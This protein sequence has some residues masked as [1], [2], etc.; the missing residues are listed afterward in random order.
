MKTRALTFIVLI[1]SIGFCSSRAGA[2]QAKPS[3][4]LLRY[5]V[6]VDFS[7]LTRYAGATDAGFGGRFTYNINRHIALEA[8]G[9]F[10]PGKCATC[11]G[12]LTGHITEGL[13]GIKAGQRFKK[14]GIFGKARPGLIN[15][16]KGYADIFPTGG[17]FSLTGGSGPFPFIFRERGHT[18]FAAD[19]GGVLEIYP[20][21]RFLLRFDAGATFDRV[22]RHT[23]HYV[24]IDP[25][26]FNPTPVTF[27]SS[28]YT[29]RYFQFSAGVGFRF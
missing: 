28:A 6:G 19:L 22:G 29:R 23:F 20:K 10:F 9:Y 12:E 18:D 25:V 21:K 15:F 17:S 7:S 3:E 5:E 26:T 27:T 13:F 11:N 1:A 8:A 24:D 4:E 2:Q 14:F 16:S